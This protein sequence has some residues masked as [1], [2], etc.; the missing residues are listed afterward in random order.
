MGKLGIL[1]GMGPLATQ[2]LYKM[3]INNTAASRDQDHI[4][5]IILSHAKIPDRTEAIQ[6]GN[7]KKIFH[8]LLD[9]VLMLGE[10][11]CTAVAIPC[12]TAHYF[13]DALQAESDI[14]IINMVKAA[15]DDL[16]AEKPSVKK[17]GI[18]ST[19][20]TIYSDIYK[21]ECIKLGI[22]AVYPAPEIQ[23]TIMNIIYNQ[24]KKGLSGNSADFAIIDRHLKDMGCD[25]AILGCTELS[26]YKENNGLPSFYIDALESLCKKSIVMCGGK[27][28]GEL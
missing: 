7:T 5:M 13:Y 27:L 3:I 16:R 21:K 18:L 20:G 28:K 9:D 8:A 6:S 4:D 15:I 12:N 10:N 17:I 1:G 2:L 14:P 19:D 11:G 22:E 26:C 23:K 24:I 25:G